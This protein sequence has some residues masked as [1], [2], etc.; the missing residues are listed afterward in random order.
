MSFNCPVSPK[1][2]IADAGVLIDCFDEQAYATQV[3]TLLHD[4]EKLRMLQRKAVERARCFYQSR[5]VSQ[6]VKLVE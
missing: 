1:E 6:W 2:V 4:K 5:I 3:I